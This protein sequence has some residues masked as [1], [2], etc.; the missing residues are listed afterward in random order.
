MNELL[1][2]SSKKLGSIDRLEKNIVR[3]NNQI[4]FYYYARGYIILFVFI[5][6][7]LKTKL[8]N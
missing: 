5:R 4:A 1:L 3:D 7:L 2:F 8:F 6:K